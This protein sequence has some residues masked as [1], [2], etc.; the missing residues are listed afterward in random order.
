MAHPVDTRVGNQ[1]K[2]CMRFAHTVRLGVTDTC[3]GLV[4]LFGVTDTHFFRFGV[5]DAC[6]GLVWMLGVTDEKF[7]LFRYEH[8][9]Q[10]R[11]TA[12]C[13]T[14]FPLPISVSPGIT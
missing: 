12:R 5:T 13:A 10:K 8:P 9:Q 3:P 14:P 4:W 7:G 11:P 6:P 2:L 1:T